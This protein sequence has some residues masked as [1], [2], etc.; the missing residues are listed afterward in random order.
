MLC[1]RLSAVF[2]F[3]AASCLA[4]SGSV[5]PPK[6]RLSEVQ[7]VSAVRYRAE[8]TL[9]PAKD[10]FSGS[11][12]I[13]LDVH[14]PAAVIWLNATQIVV[15]NALATVDGKD[16]R[17]KILPGG[18][19]FLG[20][21]FDSPLAAGR[22]ELRIRYS[23]EVRQKDTAGIFSIS[24][25]GDPYIF[26]QFESTD[27]RDAFPCFDEPSYKVPWQ[28]TLHVPEADRAVSNSPV[29]SE[30][31]DAGMR[32][33]VFRET[34]PLPSYLVAFA[35]GP[36]EFVDAG[37]AGQKHFPVRIVTPKGEAASARYAAEVTATILT[38]LE[39]YFGVPFPY[40]KSDQVAV[41]ALGFGAMENAGMVT[42]AYTTILSKP[43]GDTIARQRQYATV[44]AHEL[45]HQWFGDL[46]TTSWW[47]DV[48]LNEAFASW[49]EQKLVA[50]WRPEWNT[51]VSDVDTKLAAER[52][53]SLMSARKIRQQIEAKGEIDNAFDSIT[54]NKGAAV[55]G[56]FE[57]WIGAETFRQGVQAYLKRY[58]YKSA[59]SGDFLDSLSSS[60]KR[61]VTRAFSTFLNQ[62]GVPLV[63]V[64]LE[65]GG[66]RP[67]LHLEQSRSFPIGSKGSAKQTWQ[68]P[69]CVRY[70]PGQEERECTLMSEPV[71]D[72]PLHNA[73]SCPT[74]VDANANEAG[75]Y[76][77][78]YRG[79]LLSALARPDAAKQLKAAERSGLMGDVEALSQAGKVPTAEAL[80]VAETFH[81]DSSRE[82][83]QRSLDVALSVALDLVPSNL[84]V[85]YQRFI[86]KNYGARAHELG[87]TP[88][89]GES[90]DVG[91]LR[92]KL[93]GAV[94]QHGG[95]RELSAQARELADRWLR[96][97][98]GP[99]PEVTNAVL[100]TAAFHGDLALFR[101]FLAEFEKSTDRQD[102]QRLVN[103]MTS[104]R[105]PAAVQEGLQAVLSGQVR[106]VDAYPLLL[107]AG[108]QSAATRKVPFEFIRTHFQE[109]VRGNP[110]IFGF[111]LAASLPE[112]G[113]G[114]C[115]S[116]SRD[117]LQSFFGPIAD[118]YEGV[119]HNLAKTLE[120]VDLCVAL[121]AKQGASVRAFLENY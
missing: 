35:V 90:D 58:S 75:Y 56:M 34:K 87:W 83:L 97:R 14:K 16:R 84:E 13:F 26:T 93:V 59:T 20:L 104:F 99:A 30:T 4:A 118:K 74:W 107:S 39:E 10:R 121:V 31:V 69:I 52:E 40:E 42:Y 41:P 98:T 65:C 70:S 108:R 45:S 9:D 111:T 94:A 29:E 27:A 103:A 85:N 1:M 109:L 15:Q 80:R 7:D 73:K 60:S 21:Q 100:Q 102:K 8:L 24:Q 50:E 68:I 76:R 106:L 47:D 78:D 54:Y 5:Q 23:G 64:A 22:S 110:S 115:D 37:T 113:Q 33:Y 57:S 12:Q 63:S 28:L 11:V 120:G 3:V 117:Q 32:T 67:T 61:D 96:D 92:P 62:A 119:P 116:G 6:L 66:A 43:G 49:M 77:V 38:R 44:A 91:L 2:P 112:A 17:A 55:I 82:V 71:M 101:R 88:Q 72:W 25:G 81:N 51:R 48:W 53:D 19:D 105:D 89:P 86:Q 36:F 114:L 46:V 79:G 18:D 95:D